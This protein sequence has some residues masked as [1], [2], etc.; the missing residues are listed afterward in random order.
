MQGIKKGIFNP[1][2][3]IKKEKIA[4]NAVR[5]LDKG[6]TSVSSALNSV[7]DYHQFLVRGNGLDH[8]T[9]QKELA[10]TEQLV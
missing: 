7:M 4:L 1:E 10:A 8:T 3:L 9:Q 6:I 2:A 5:D